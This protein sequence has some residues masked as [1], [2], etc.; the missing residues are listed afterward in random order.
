MPAC[1]PA[2]SPSAP[3]TTFS[4]SG[5]PGRLVKTISHCSATDLGVSAH[6]AP[7]SRCRLAASRR[8][9]VTTSLYCDFWR[10][11]AMKA[12]MVPRPMNP[13]FMVSPLRL[14][15]RLVF[16]L[17]LGLELLHRRAHRGH[18]RG[19]A[20]IDADMQE[21][22]FQLFARQAVVHA[23]ADMRLQ[24]LGAAQRLQHGDGDDAACHAFQPRPSPGRGEAMLEQ[25]LPQVACHLVLRGL[26]E[27]RLC[28]LGA[29]H[30]EPHVAAG[31]ERV[32]L[33]VRILGQ[34]IPSFCRSGCRGPSPRWRVSR[35]SPPKSPVTAG[36]PQINTTLRSVPIWICMTYMQACK[37]DPRRRRLL[38]RGPGEDGEQ[39]ESDDGRRRPDMFA[40]IDD[41]G[42][43][44]DHDGAPQPRTPQT[45][46]CPGQK[47]GR[48]E[49][50][51]AGD[52]VEPVRIAPAL[53][54]GGG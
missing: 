45:S 12:P 51:P 47:S 37:M 27:R 50:Q 44:R 41:G 52:E 23:H 1:A 4:T 19:H 24:L 28:H 40:V 29:A 42:G 43:C 11:A 21:D 2:K 10:L 9:S 35:P 32:S 5:G 39:H 46:R 25:E 48:R 33:V 17:I 15:L 13:I 7:F 54:F 18:G 38:A 53:V 30:L 6:S 16:C 22:L 3:K 8:M 20:G 26:I 31:L 14:V 49:L 36:L 34:S